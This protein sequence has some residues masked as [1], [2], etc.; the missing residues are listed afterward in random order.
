[1]RTYTDPGTEIVSGVDEA[2][3]IELP[4][5]PS[6]GYTWKIQ[7]PPG[8][9]QRSSEIVADPEVETGEGMVG[10]PA[11]QRFEFAAEVTGAT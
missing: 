6:T 9:I 5:N 2:F 1:M 8:I 7:L 11:V 4:I 10:V 3:A